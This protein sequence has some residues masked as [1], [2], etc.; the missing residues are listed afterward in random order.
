MV[1]PS[2]SESI[3]DYWPPS[4]LWSATVFLL[5]FALYVLKPARDGLLAASGALGIE[6]ADLKAWT[7]LLQALLLVT[8]TPLYVRASRLASRRLILVGVKLAFA[9]QLLLLWAADPAAG[10]SSVGFY[11]SV[12]ILSLVVV[13]EFWALVVDR[14]GDASG[15]KVIPLIALAGSAGAVA[16]SWCVSYGVGRGFIDTTALLPIAAAALLGA[17][18]CGW[19]ASKRAVGPAF[20]IAIPVTAS[21]PATP[22]ASPLSLVLGHKYLCAAALVVA[23][24]NW[25]G[26]TGET[27]LFASVQTLL[28]HDAAA[29]GVVEVDALRRFVAD[30]TTGFYA[31]F[32]LW[33]NLATLL[34]Q[35]TVVSPL[36]RLRGLKPLLLIVPVVAILTYAAAA[37]VPMLGVLKLAKV[38]ETATSRSVASTANHLVWL[39]TPR[40][41]KRRAKALVDTV[42]VRIGDVMAVLTLFVGSHLFHL[43]TQQLYVVNVAL[44]GLWLS[45]ASVLAREHRRLDA[46]E[47]QQGF[48]RTTLPAS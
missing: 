10:F 23:A 42:F 48:L 26:T 7:I 3:S 32:F 21:K 11:V 16:G 4:L 40:H 14:F 44:A 46:G 45:G 35:A 2:P 27:L 9:L 24:I 12:G 39:S 22:P 15:E 1:E 43:S 13:A 18:A 31:S 36:A 6:K 41:M 5:L 8:L 38:A 34:L 25:V 30:G 47:L 33:A 37:L 20:A 17:S 29:R 19:C 28:E